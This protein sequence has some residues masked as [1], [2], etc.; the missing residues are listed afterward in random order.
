VRG[1]DSSLPGTN[2]NG[3]SGARD[4]TPSAGKTEHGVVLVVDSDRKT[5]QVC[6]SGLKALGYEVEVAP[7]TFEAIDALENRRFDLVLADVALPEVGG[8]LNRIRERGERT[9]VVVMQGE[10]TTWAAV[11]ALRLGAADFLQKPLRPLDAEFALIKS[12]RRPRQ[13]KAAPSR[14][15]HRLLHE[16][17]ELRREATA[18]IH[19]METLRTIWAGLTYTEDEQQII[20]VVLDSVFD[21]LEPDIVALTRMDAEGTVARAFILSQHPV[22]DRPLQELKEKIS[23]SLAHC[24]PSLA[25]Q[26]TPTLS[27]AETRSREN[28]DRTDGD[29]S[30]F[31]SVPLTAHGKL[32]GS[33]SASAS[34]ADAFT[35]RSTK[36]LSAIGACLSLSLGLAASQQALVDANLETIAA[37]GAA[38]EARDRHAYGH[39]ERDARFAVA[40]AQRMGLSDTQTRNVQIGALLHDIGKIGISYRI[41]NKRG[42][43][44][45]RDSQEF[46]KHPVLGAQIVAKIGHLQAIVPLVRHHHERFDGSGY[47]AGLAG[48]EL[49]LETRILAVADAFGA[50]TDDRA[51][52]TARSLEAALAELKKGAGTQF[53]AKVVEAFLALMQDEEGRL[54]L[55]DPSAARDDPAPVT[56]A[57]S[58]AES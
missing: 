50:M 6:E 26:S 28:G 44:T 32:L 23:S 57:P 41:L 13:P 47:P 37:L 7:D 30:S 53:D 49:P 46:Q 29:I 40:L 5:V 12:R 38:L 20:E 11:H 24:L 27:V 45:A 34:Q 21:L 16:V 54:L 35:R 52:R 9:P 33:L 39:A 10:A 2:E 22:S 48:E 51:H 36:A 15:K 31:I 14:A 19:E 42:P 58:C 43:L 1:F 55:A 25:D 8:L 3:Q 17:E 56:P 4:T 18:S